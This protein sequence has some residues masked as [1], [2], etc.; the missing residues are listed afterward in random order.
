MTEL[1]REKQD[2]FSVMRR[3]TGESADPREQF[4]ITPSVST[5]RANTEG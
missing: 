4:I 2:K 5:E 3:E 1:L